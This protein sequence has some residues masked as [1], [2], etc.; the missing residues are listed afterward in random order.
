MS[1][2][3][4][5]CNSPVIKKSLWTMIYVSVFA[6][7]WCS[8]PPPPPPP[9]HPPPEKISLC[10]WTETKSLTL[11]FC[12]WYQI[13]NIQYLKHKHGK[14]TINF[15]S[16]LPMILCVSIPPFVS[17]CINLDRDQ[18]IN[19]CLF[20]HKVVLWCLTEIFKLT[21]KKE[22]YVGSFLSVSYNER[23]SAMHTHTKVV[24]AGSRNCAFT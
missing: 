14:C 18:H 9:P 16:F 10:S 23:N 2:L 12:H 17:S 24:S 11:I 8:N 4:H 1:D 20:F 5:V 6:T 22:D 19:I 3:R 21:K 15:I 13:R 7:L